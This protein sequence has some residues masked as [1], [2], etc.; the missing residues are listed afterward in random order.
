MNKKQDT[1]KTKEL[2]MNLKVYSVN[3]SMFVN[4]FNIQVIE[5]EI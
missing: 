2:F 1:R 5:S 3:Y 4:S